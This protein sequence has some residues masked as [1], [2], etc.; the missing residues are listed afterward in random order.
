MVAWLWVI[1]LLLCF[2][3]KY[4]KK[5][6]QVTKIQAWFFLFDVRCDVLLFLFLG[7]PDLFLKM[8]MYCETRMFFPHILYNNDIQKCHYFSIYV[9]FCAFSLCYLAYVLIIQ[10]LSYLSTVTFSVIEKIIVVTICRKK[11]RRR[12]CREQMSSLYLNFLMPI[13]SFFTPPPKNFSCW[14]PYGVQ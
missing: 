8:L 7:D 1:Y 2:D 6:K 5:F 9:Y 12:E 3:I 11:C 10:S 13:F 14:I 4:T